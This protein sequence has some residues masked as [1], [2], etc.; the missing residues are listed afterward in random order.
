MK[1]VIES[2]RKFLNNILKLF[3]IKFYKLLYK[4]LEKYGTA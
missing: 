2:Q 1:S 3:F 4:L